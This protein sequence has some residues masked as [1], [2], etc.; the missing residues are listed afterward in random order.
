MS[1]LP[2][3]GILIVVLLCGTAPAQK[4]RNFEKSATT[5]PSKSSSSKGNKSSSKKSGVGLPPVV[6]GGGNRDIGYGRMIIAGYGDALRRM[7]PQATTVE[8]REKGEKMLPLFRVDMDYQYIDSDVEA[9]GLHLETGYGPFAAQM[10]QSR[11]TEDNGDDL[12]ATAIN[13]L[14]RATYAKY[15]EF[16]MGAGAFQ[17]NGE[18]ENWGFHVTTP[19]LVHINDHVGF[20]YRPSWTTLKG[21]SIREGD[22]AMMFGRKS[23]SL[24]VG[25]RTLQSPSLELDGF[26]AGVSLHW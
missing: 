8:P 4:L 5:K 17:L 11:F 14:L 22:L 9:I 6:F 2:L 18:D 13:L 24:K 21:N 12:N 3:A 7:D 19:F 10:R 15:F 25:Y 26:F 1:K 20:E 16:D 23:T